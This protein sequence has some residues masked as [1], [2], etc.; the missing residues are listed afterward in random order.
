MCPYPL[1]VQARPPWDQT[2]ATQSMVSGQEEKTK[3]K[4]STL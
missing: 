4:K 3:R 1:K 2:P